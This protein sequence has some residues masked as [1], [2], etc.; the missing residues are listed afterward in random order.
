[1]GST[2][3]TV[4]YLRDKLSLGPRC[5]ARTRT[6]FAGLHST[7]MKYAYSFN[8]RARRELAHATLRN[9]D[10]PTKYTLHSP[11]SLKKMDR[12]RVHCKGGVYLTGLEYPKTKNTSKSSQTIK[13]T[14]S[15]PPP[16]GGPISL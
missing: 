12:E 15:L 10:P 3:T 16:I 14:H 2:N 8:F 9:I 11:G 5:K 4:S 1:M 13:N 7:K 6:A